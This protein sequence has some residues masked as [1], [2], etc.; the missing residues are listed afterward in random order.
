MTT[1]IPR[2]ALEPVHLRL[3]RDA[4]DKAARLCADAHAQAASIVAQ[5]QQEAAAA[6]AAAAA[7]ATATAEPLTTAE[8]R[9]ARE[10]ARSA[11]LS[12]QRAACDELRRRVRA[13]VAALPAAEGYD[14]LLQRI[15]RLAG[16]A[17]GPDAELKF[18]PAGGVVARR[19]GVVVD[20]SLDRLAELA[21]T[22]LG[23]AVTK[24][25]AP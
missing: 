4:E 21:V 25:W 10:A 12:A 23:A 5:A 18:P 22:E 13:A 20:C 1:G 11:V 6:L 15:T 9:Q 19:A 8:L 24:L 3:R 16:Q 14:L 17:A 2:A 7:Q